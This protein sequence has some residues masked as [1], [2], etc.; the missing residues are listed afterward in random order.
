[1]QS[2][3]PEKVESASVHFAMK[4]AKWIAIFSLVLPLLFFTW[5][6]TTHISQ[7]REF[8]AWRIEVQGYDPRH[9]LKG[10]YITYRFNYP[11]ADGAATDCSD[12]R[13]SCC[14]CLRGARENPNASLVNC[15][16]A[17]E[18]KQCQGLLRKDYKGRD[19]SKKN[20]SIGLT[21]YYV[22]ERAAKTLDK[23][24]RNNE[25]SM[26]VDVLLAPKGQNGHAQMTRKARLGEL[27]IDDKPL[28]AILDANELPF[29]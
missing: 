16:T 22:D 25:I 23:M 18:T 13:T 27:Y 1:M 3:L 6:V 11:W 20:F 15:E 9:I 8:E 12:F 19:R 29:E 26:S 10:R 14:L 4:N 17:L 7:E 24:L 5:Q 21:E 28:S 2:N